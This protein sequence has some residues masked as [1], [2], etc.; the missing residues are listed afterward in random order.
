MKKTLFLITVDKSV[1]G[2]AQKL[3]KLI[4]ERGVS[5]VPQ[6]IEEYEALI[7]LPFMDVNDEKFIFIV[8]TLNGLSR[9]TIIKNS[10][11]NRFACSIGMEENK[12]VIFAS[13]N[14]LPLVDYKKFRDYC[15]GMQLDYPDVVVPHENP[16]FENAEAIKD[17]F[18]KKDNQSINNAQYSTLVYE[19]VKNYFDEFINYELEKEDIKDHT[20]SQKDLKDAVKVMKSNALTNLTFKQAALCHAIIHSAAIACSVIAFIPV[21]VVDAVP[22]TA[23]QITMAIGLGKVFDNKITKSDAQII[24]KTAGAA[25]VGRAIAKNA[26]VFIPGIGWGINGVIAGYITE[27]LGW[28]IANDF[29]VKQNKQM[30]K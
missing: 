30:R 22:M 24:L 21:P 27:I 16:I 15:R 1:S 12:C 19:F 17:F 11:Y 14:E 20:N 23:T 10:V 25:L 5:V 18:G 4:E 8:R 3:T 6:T 28:T 13:D 7:S 26:F 29:A 2:Y 9:V